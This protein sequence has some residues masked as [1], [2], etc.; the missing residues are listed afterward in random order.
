MSEIKS[1]ELILQ[2]RNFSPVEKLLDL[3]EELEDDHQSLLQKLEENPEWSGVLS[4]IDNQKL[5]ERVLTGV[6]KC[7][8][9]E[10]GHKIKL[11]EIDQKNPK[12]GNEVKQGV[13]MYH[14]KKQLPDGRT[15]IEKVS[16]EQE[17]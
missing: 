14:Q 1:I 15:I 9:V 16:I 6:V 13:I 3:Y 7:K 12:L 2:Q 8:Q 17:E 5:R 11:L 4:P 10:D